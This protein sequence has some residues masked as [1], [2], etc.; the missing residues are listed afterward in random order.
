MPKL[1]KDRLDTWAVL[2]LV[3]IVLT[4]TKG[5]ET[6][7]ADW[8]DGLDTFMRY[9]CHRSWLGGWLLPQQK[10]YFALHL[11]CGWWV[12]GLDQALHGDIDI[13]QFKYFSEIA[14][15]KVGLLSL[16]KSRN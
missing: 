14:R 16:I 8:F 11:P 6:M 3:F 9:I 13:F 12:F 2:K 1:G 4:R 7:S 10:S 15:E 5:N